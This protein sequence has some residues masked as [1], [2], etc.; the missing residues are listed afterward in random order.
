MRRVRRKRAR[1]A[2]TTV[3]HLEGVATRTPAGQAAGISVVIAKPVNKN[4]ASMAVRTLTAIII[5]GWTP[6]FP[7][8]P[9]RRADGPVRDQPIARPQTKHGVAD[10]FGKVLL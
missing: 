7:G 5:V 9:G 6:N 2:S 8:A 3:N 10:T 4:H 1:N